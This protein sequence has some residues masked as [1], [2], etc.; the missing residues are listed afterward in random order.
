MWRVHYYLAWFLYIDGQEAMCNA[1]KDLGRNQI[2]LM[3]WLQ[4]KKK[5]P[6]EIN[7]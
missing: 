7:T 3:L 1:F 2:V 6:L 4:K 5:K